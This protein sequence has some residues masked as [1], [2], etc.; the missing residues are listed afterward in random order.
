MGERCLEQRLVREPNRLGMEPC[1]REEQPD[2]DDEDTEDTARA[3]GSRDHERTPI[4]KAGPVSGSAVLA[5]RNDSDD[6]E[7]RPVANRL[8]APP[9]RSRLAAL[10]DERAPGRGRAR[11]GAAEPP[12]P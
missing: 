1:G 10:R 2:E 11:R 6:G 8:R 3:R 7:G 4:V 9:S 12:R 5:P